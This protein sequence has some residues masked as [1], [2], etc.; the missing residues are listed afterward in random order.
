MYLLRHNR[1]TGLLSAYIIDDVELSPWSGKV[2]KR[3]PKAWAY[4]DGHAAIDVTVDRAMSAL[5][6]VATHVTA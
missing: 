3:R 5:T 4:N 1:L 6:K 2:C